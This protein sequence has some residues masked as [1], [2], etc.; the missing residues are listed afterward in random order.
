MQEIPVDSQLQVTF[1]PIYL[2]N[3]TAGQRCEAG[4]ASSCF[5]SSLLGFFL[6]CEVLTCHFG[7]SKS[8]QEQ[9]V[10][11]FSNAYIF[12]KSFR[13]FKN[14][15]F[16][17]SFFLGFF[18]VFFFFSNCFTPFLLQGELCKPL[19]VNIGLNHMHFCAAAAAFHNLFLDLSMKHHGQSQ[20]YRIHL[21]PGQAFSPIKML[22]IFVSFQACTSRC[23]DLWLVRVQLQ[24]VFLSLYRYITRIKREHAI[25]VQ[26]V[27][28][29]LLVQ[30]LY[31][32]MA[33]QIISIGFYFLSLSTFVSSQWGE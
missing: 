13:V 19:R 11:L 17:D 26:L 3:G 4:L 27:G 28:P 25:S 12:N 20:G 32:Y 23:A 6:F 21:S 7:L 14:A 18:W 8:H 1:L 22:Q 31:Q 16:S 2:E 5:Y 33:T 30:K 9:E 29:H 10:R 24:P 15:T